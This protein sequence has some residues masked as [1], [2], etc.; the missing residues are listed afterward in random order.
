M[1]AK[2]SGVAALDGSSR[3]YEA[4]KI[5][6]YDGTI[7]FGLSGC[8]CCAPGHR[9]DGLHTN[10]VSQWFRVNDGAWQRVERHITW[11]KEMAARSMSA[12]AFL[13]TSAAAFLQTL[14]KE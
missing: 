7:E 8:T 4:M 14:A 6:K 2:A 11:Y 3:D 5:T 12:A 9:H 10:A 1:R 13:Q